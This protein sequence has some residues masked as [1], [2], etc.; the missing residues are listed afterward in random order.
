MLQATQKAKIGKG[1]TKKVM[2]NSAAVL[3]FRQARKPIKDVY[4]QALM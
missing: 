4:C 1:T 2:D 3:K